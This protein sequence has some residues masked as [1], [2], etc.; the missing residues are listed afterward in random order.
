MAW[1]EI[2]T[3]VF[4]Y[5]EKK[6]AAHGNHKSC[7]KIIK[8]IN[9]KDFILI[10]GKDQ[11]D[12]KILKQGPPTLNEASELKEEETYRGDENDL[13]LTAYH[14]HDFDCNFGE[15]CGKSKYSNLA[16]TETSG[17]WSGFDGFANS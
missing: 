13:L 8:K 1:H 6:L 14:Q 7:K 9:T 10:S 15:K 11:V 2:F 17:Q 3:L 5:K 16:I 12:V 4:F